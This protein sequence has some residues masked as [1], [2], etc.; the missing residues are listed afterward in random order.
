MKVFLEHLFYALIVASF[1]A[2]GTIA[3]VYAVWGVL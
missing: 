1:M 2:T 3:I